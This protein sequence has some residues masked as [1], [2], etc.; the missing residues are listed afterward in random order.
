MIRDSDSNTDKTWDKTDSQE[1]FNRQIQHTN[2][3]SF[4][5]EHSKYRATKEQICYR[6]NDCWCLEYQHDCS[7]LNKVELSQLVSNQNV[8]RQTTIGR[9]QSDRFHA[10]HCRSTTYSLERIIQHTVIRKVLLCLLTQ[11]TDNSMI[12]LFVHNWLHNLMKHFNLQLSKCF[13]T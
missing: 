3:S 8:I 10:R 7:M 11:I 9:L 2:T 13:Y 4:N 6:G 1:R 5:S 12:V